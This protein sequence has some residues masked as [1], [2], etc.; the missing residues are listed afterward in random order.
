MPDVNILIY[1]HRTDEAVHEAYARW[2]TDLVESRE[3]FSLS[4]LVAVGFLRIATSPRIYREPTS[5]PTALAFIEELTSQSGCRVA[6]PG[7]SHVADVIGLCRGTAATG[8]T[9][10][11]AQHAA[12][13]MAEGATWV[14]RDSDFAKFG[15][16]GLRWQHLSL[17]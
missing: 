7:P 4:A 6:V 13:A 17:D 15:P 16:H 5:L 12:L 2:L 10:A 1:A 9:I 8:A 11:D 3:P 14:T